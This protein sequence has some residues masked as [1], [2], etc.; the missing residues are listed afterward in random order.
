LMPNYPN[1]FNPETWIPFKLSMDTDVTIEIYDVAGHLV[2]R[3]QLGYIPAGY[4]VTREKSAYWDGRNEAGEKTT[5]GVYFYTI[6]TVEYK[7]VRKM[8]IMR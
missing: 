4:Y 3:L 6:R 7:S 1:P 2:R 8:V 5:S